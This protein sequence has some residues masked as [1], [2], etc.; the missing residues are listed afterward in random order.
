MRPATTIVLALILIALFSAVI[1]QFVVLGSDVS[2][3]TIA[4]TTQALAARVS[5]AVRRA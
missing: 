5:T 1:I 4:D 2:T 3:T